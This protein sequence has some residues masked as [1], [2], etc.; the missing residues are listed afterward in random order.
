MTNHR[1][2]GSVWALVFGAISCLLAA[3]LLSLTRGEDAQ[4]YEPNWWLVQ[5]AALTTLISCSI[6]GLGFVALTRWGVLGIRIVGPVVLLY[7]TA[8][9][10]FGGERPW[11]SNVAIFGLFLFVAYS[12]YLAIKQTARN[13][14]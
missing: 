12:I 4:Y 11:W 3:N 14:A 9:G 2:I 7:L 10:V 8:Y 13:A 1:V 6:V 5:I